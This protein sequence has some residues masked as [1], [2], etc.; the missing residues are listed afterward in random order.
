MVTSKA[1]PNRLLSTLLLVVL[2]PLLQKCKSNNP[3]MSAVMFASFTENIDINDT[4]PVTPVVNNEFS[5]IAYLADIMLYLKNKYPKEFKTMDDIENKF[6]NDFRHLNTQEDSD[7]REATAYVSFAAEILGNVLLEQ[8]GKNWRQPF[9]KYEKKNN[10]NYLFTKYVSKETITELYN[11]YLSDTKIDKDDIKGF[12]GPSKDVKLDAMHINKELYE[13][14]IA[15]ENDIDVSLLFSLKHQ[16]YIRTRVISNENTE[17]KYKKSI[18]DSVMLGFYNDFFAFRKR[19][20]EKVADSLIT[21]VENKDETLI[22][23]QKKRK[24]GSRDKRID[25]KILNRAYTIED[26]VNNQVAKFIDYGLDRPPVVAYFYPRINFPLLPDTQ[27]V[28][29]YQSF[30]QGNPNI[31]HAPLDE[32]L[33]SVT[34]KIYLARLAQSTFSSLI[35]QESAN[36]AKVEFRKAESRVESDFYK[37]IRDQLADAIIR[38]GIE[39]VKNIKDLEATYG[40]NITG[41][42][43]EVITRTGFACRQIINW[44]L[45]RENNLSHWIGSYDTWYAAKTVVNFPENFFS[46]RYR[47]NPTQAFQAA[48]KEIDENTPYN[49]VEANYIANPEVQQ[50]G[51]NRTNI[52]YSHPD[53]TKLTISKVEHLDDFHYYL[54]IAYVEQLINNKNF[55]EAG[56]FINNWLLQYIKGGDDVVSNAA[57]LNDSLVFRTEFLIHYFDTLQQI[58]SEKINEDP[59]EPYFVAKKYPASFIEHL[60]LVLVKNYTDWADMIYFNASDVRPVEYDKALKKYEIAQQILHRYLKKQVDDFINS[61]PANTVEDFLTGKNNI[62]L[63]ITRGKLGN[64]YFDFYDNKIKTQIT[65]LNAFQ[66]FNGRERVSLAYLNPTNPY[67]NPKFLDAIQKTK[68]ELADAGNSIITPE[69]RF[70]YLIDL[71][72]KQAENADGLEKNLLQAIEKASDRK[73]SLLRAK[74]ALDVQN[75]TVKSTQFSIN[76]MQDQILEKL[77]QYDRIKKQQQYYNNLLVNGLNSNEKKAINLQLQAVNTSYAAVAV[78]IAREAAS[79]VPFFGG[80]GGNPVSTLANAFSQQ[81]SSYLTLASYDRRQQEWE[82][83]RDLLTKD[84]GIADINLKQARTQL[85]IAKQQHK[86]SLLEQQ[87]AERY[88]DFMSERFDQKAFY[89]WMARRLEDVHNQRLLDA[90][91]LAKSAELALKYE[92][93]GEPD[94]QNKVYVDAPKLLNKQYKNITSA[95]QLKTII[96]KMENDYRER[97]AHQEQDTYNIS[98]RKENPRAFYDFVHNHVA[99]FTVDLDWFDRWLPGDYLRR[100]KKISLTLDANP[101]AGSQPRLELSSVGYSKVMLGDPFTDKELMII[102]SNTLNGI[103]RERFSIP[104]HPVSDRV[105]ER[106]EAQRG[107]VSYDFTEGLGVANS[108]HL[109]M[110]TLGGLDSSNIFDVNLSINYTYKRSD[111]YRDIILKKKWG[112]VDDEGFITQEEIRYFPLKSEFNWSGKGDTSI[113]IDPVSFLSGGTD[114]HIKKVGI[115]GVFNRFNSQSG[116]IQ[117]TFKPEDE[118][119]P[120]RTIPIELSK[121]M[122]DSYQWAGVSPYGTYSITGLKGSGIKLSDLQD[123]FLVVEYSAKYQYQRIKSSN[124]P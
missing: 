21:E 90:I 82:F 115:L 30:F 101:N 35:N 27:F 49:T 118:N 92:L 105:N 98:L 116:K 83:Q 43:D 96:E 75:E 86:V 11:K 1:I 89:N 99:D 39:G 85:D 50:A 60:V 124:T 80:S 68:S 70:S 114:H 52:T 44:I 108:W 61:T 113:K 19:A 103:H 29:Q 87:F 58:P 20:K 94:I 67:A 110:V 78:E 34:S 106:F 111:K 120:A 97:L 119:L 46:G 56:K 91:A 2:V 53:Q 109:E 77:E 25:N 65:R 37:T 15:D 95:I 117:L 66:N 26:S 12:K 6:K 28:K 41:N 71:A 72:K 10:I 64:I 14:I 45:I 3:S 38:K 24:Q 63:E 47:P 93:I 54:R 17:E 84:I 31:I 81:A 4:I 40:T 51:L 22:A 9:D 107:T 102:Q 33:D 88:L 8:D 73:E 79:H 74:Q 62:L 121:S 36:N 5:E 18:R 59:F 32:M 76:Q 112:G 16:L 13:L 57:D 104:F 122:K 55:E 48:M 7:P 42:K 69:Y 123:L 23:L 100:I